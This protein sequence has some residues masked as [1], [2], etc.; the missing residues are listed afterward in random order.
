MVKSLPLCIVMGYPLG[1]ISDVISK[2]LSN[3]LQGKSRVGIGNPLKIAA[4]WGRGGMGNVF[5][6]VLAGFFWQTART[7][8]LGG[9]LSLW[10]IFRRVYRYRYH[11][12]IFP[13]TCLGEN[14]AIPHKN[15]NLM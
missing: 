13:L 14:F 4:G 3:L 9:C 1:K 5:R 7:Y 15:L 10:I 11:L 6:R 8:L 2:P 12:A